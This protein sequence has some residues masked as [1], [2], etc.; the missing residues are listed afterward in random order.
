MKIT[1]QKLKVT[2]LIFKENLENNESKMVFPQKQGGGSGPCGKFHKKMFF[3]KPSL[4]NIKQ[5]P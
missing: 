1:T 4:S 5:N 3:F 2:P